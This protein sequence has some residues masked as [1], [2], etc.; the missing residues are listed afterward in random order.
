MG[1][2]EKCLGQEWDHSVP[3]LSRCQELFDKIL[4]N[5]SMVVVEGSNWCQEGTDGAPYRFPA[6]R[7]VNL[8]GEPRLGLRIQ[9][10]DT[11]CTFSG[12]DAP[13]SSPSASPTI[14]Q[15]TVRSR[16]AGATHAPRYV[17][18]GLHDKLTPR[19]H[20]TTKHYRG[21]AL[22][23]IEKRSDSVEPPVSSPQ[24]SLYGTRNGGAL[25]SPYGS[26]RKERK[27]HGTRTMLAGRLYT[28][29]S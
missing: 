12:R 17:A 6:G 4:I 13:G 20:H 10:L 14:S 1:R 18:L 9:L 29:W 16:F 28:F 21:I 11:G 15:L 22:S 23:Q 7:L 25:H 24:G 27:S 26:K 5:H 3:T 8:L 19:K 2:L